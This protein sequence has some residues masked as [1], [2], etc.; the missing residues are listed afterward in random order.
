[1]LLDWVTPV[2]KKENHLKVVNKEAK[3]VRT[4]N[5]LFVI[6]ERLTIQQMFAGET[7]QIQTLSSNSRVNII[8]ATSKDIGH[9]NVEPRS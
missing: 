3:K 7:M 9:M 6:V 5:P 8:G 4:T 2:L 1:M